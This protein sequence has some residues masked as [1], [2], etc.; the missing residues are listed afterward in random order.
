MNRE[1]VRAIPLRAA[2]ELGFSS[3]GDEG[4]VEMRKSLQG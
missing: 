2:I 3:P 4:I 1:G